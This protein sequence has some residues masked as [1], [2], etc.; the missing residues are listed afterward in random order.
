MY[1]LEF[2][3]FEVLNQQVLLSGFVLQMDS[4]IAFFFL[5]YI[6]TALCLHLKIFNYH[7]I[8]I[9]YSQTSSY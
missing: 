9:L 1:R 2:R 6:D 5:T 7:L 4:N 8:Q 3:H